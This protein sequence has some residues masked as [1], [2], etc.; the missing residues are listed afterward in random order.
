MVSWV[1]VI[2]VSSV[3]SVVMLSMVLP[4]AYLNGNIALLH[5]S[6]ITQDLS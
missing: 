6:N 4:A 1:G 2:S 3:V 5:R